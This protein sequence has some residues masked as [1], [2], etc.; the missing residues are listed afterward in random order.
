LVLVVPV[1]YLQPV[2]YRVHLLYSV[3][4][5]LLAVDMVALFLLV[6]GPAVLA[7]VPEQITVRPLLVGL[8]TLRQFHPRKEIMAG[9]V[10]RDRGVST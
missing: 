3:P 10:I 1:G 7:A 2:E 4:L 5:H 9:L 8:A 6:V